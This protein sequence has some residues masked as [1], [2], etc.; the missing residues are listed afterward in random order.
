MKIYPTVTAIVPTYNRED[1]ILECVH[2]L[3]TQS[4]PLSEILV[5]DDGSTDNTRDLLLQYQYKIR[6]LHKDRIK[7]IYK[8]NGGKSSALNI[9]LAQ[10]TSDFI[11]IC[12]DDDYADPNGL[13]HLLRVLDR[14]P[15][16]DYVYGRF[17]N[18]NVNINGEKEFTPYL[19]WKREDEVNEK[20]SFLESMFT[21][22][23]SMIVKKDLYTKVGQFNTSFTRS[24]DY[25]M[26]LRLARIGIGASTEENIYF[27]RQHAGI[28]GTSN[29]SFDAIQNQEK[30]L[31]FNKKIFAY[32]AE[33][34]S[35][36][37]FTPTF[38]KKFYDKDKILRASHLQRGIV[39]ANN[40]MW[41]IACNDFKKV[42]EI[43]S[44]PFTLAEDRLCLD[45]VHGMLVWFE[46]TKY[47]QSMAFLHSLS[48]TKQGLRFLRNF[49]R[50][51]FWIIKN[52]FKA[53][54]YKNV[55]TA[56]YILYKCM[57]IKGLVAF[58]AIRVFQKNE[59]KK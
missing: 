59:Y 43:S 30:W 3:I 6:H 7:Y 45:V 1:Y 19:F 35:I 49:T 9:G 41:D 11:W 36:D 27:Y 56:F 47:P 16:V 12:D 21:T 8:E 54:K 48:D 5:I 37:E 50:P 40:G 33:D 53:G 10:A 18:F 58:C 38:A 2:S 51:L 31:L 17:Q 39:F 57:G 4:H 44:E 26:M 46:I 29:Y 34:Y 32:V 20:I 15:N 13:K 28:R 52:N 22:H 42:F 25:E 24:Q 55:I 14:K 23:F